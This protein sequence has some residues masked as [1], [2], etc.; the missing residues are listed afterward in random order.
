[1]PSAPTALVSARASARL[2]VLI[3]M[4]AALARLWGIDFGLPHLHARPDELVSA[5]I[6]LGVLGGE[7]HPH[8]FDWPTLW[9]YVL[10]VLYLGYYLVASSAES[11]AAFTTPPHDFAPLYL[12][13]R[14]AAAA[15]GVAT[16]P[17]LY[18][19]GSRAFD[20]ATGL[21]AAL[22]L[23]VAF[24][25]VRDSHFAL[26][27]VPATFLLTA[28]MLAI[29]RAHQSGTL[30]DALLAGVLT[31][32]AAATKYNAAFLVVPMLV[33]GILRRS[34]ASLAAFGAAAAAAFVVA[35]PWAVLDAAAVLRGLARVEHHLRTGHEGLDLGRGWSYHLRVSLREGVGWPVLLAGLA[36]ALRLAAVDG[37]RAALLYAFPIVY[38]VVAGQGRTVFARHALPVLPFV[39]L[40]AAS[41]LVAAAHRLTATPRQAGRMVAALA[42]LTAVPSAW[43]VVR[44]DRLLARTDNRVLV[45]RWLE[46]AIAGGSSVYQSGAL[47]GWVTLP[48][49]HVR[50]TYD[51]AAR[52]F[53]ADGGRP[54]RDEP[55][56]IILQE[57]PL[58]L[59]SEVPSDVRELVASGRY[60]LAHAFPATEPNASGNLYDLQDAFFLPFSGFRGVVRP[61]PSFFVYRRAGQARG[62]ARRSRSVRGPLGH[63]DH[64]GPVRAREERAQGALERG[65]RPPG[66]CQPAEGR[67]AEPVVQDEAAERQWLVGANGDRTQRQGGEQPRQVRR[68]RAAC[69]DLRRDQARLQLD[70]RVPPVRLEHEQ[71][72]ARGEDADRLAQRGRRIGDVVEQVAHEDGAEDAGAEGQCGRVGDREARARHHPG[73]EAQLVGEQVDAHATHVAR[74]ADEVVPLAAAD[75][76]AGGRHLADQRLEERILRLGEARRARGPV[77]ALRVRMLEVAA[78]DVGAMRVALGHV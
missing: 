78:L 28:G 31:G 62:T 70:E 67:Q 16:I 59:Y 49:G 73:R 57:S 45:A 18:R 17:V 8:F 36:G 13:G 20:R 12:I 27:D 53:V 2:L 47:Y 60:T 52:T 24:L 51:A 4:V 48:R 69:A 21:V 56:W 7:P 77:E 11:L 6:A 44:A 41:L 29:V 3:V 14:C 58:V 66:R 68:A 64:V 46:D 72:P 50:W 23:A 61:G 42:L 33:S 15:L 65:E 75:L 22:F 34:A 37:R 39:C 74:E 43:S 9:M 30:R 5:I 1:M 54:T 32:L 40:G 10:A 71:P 63:G 76:E 26:T 55:D 19:L 35:M 25:H 38:Y